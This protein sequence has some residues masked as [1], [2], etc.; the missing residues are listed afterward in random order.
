MNPAVPFFRIAFY[1]LCVS[2]HPTPPPPQI[3]HRHCLQFLPGITVVLLFV[4][5]IRIAHETPWLPPNPHPAV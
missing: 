3:L 2:Q 4:F 5:H 1:A